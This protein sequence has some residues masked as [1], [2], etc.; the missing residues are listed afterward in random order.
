[1]PRT[2]DPTPAQYDR[3]KAKIAENV[4]RELA[5]KKVPHT[6]LPDMLGLARA[7]AA[8]RWSGETPYYAHEIAF[9]AVVLEIPASRLID[10]DHTADESA[11]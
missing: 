10:C 9:L 3:I 6:A 2:V 1:M 8:R 5:A 4:R 7:N 11:R